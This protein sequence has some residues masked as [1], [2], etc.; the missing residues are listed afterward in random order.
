M[1]GFIGQWLNLALNW[2]YGF[3]NASRT[4]FKRGVVLCLF[5]V[6]DRSALAINHYAY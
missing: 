1:E 2:M 4:A 6:N 3:P 5:F